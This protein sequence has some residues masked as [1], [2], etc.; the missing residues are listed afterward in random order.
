MI[1]NGGYGGVSSALAHGVP[2]IVAGDTEEKPEVAQ[3]VAWSGAGLNLR[4]GSPSEAKLRAAVR[5]VLADRSYRNNAIRLQA[6]IASYDAPR[7][8]CEAIERVLTRAS[9]PSAA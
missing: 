9:F 6:E 1:T 4:T 8:A 7:L 3:R 5:R 2:L